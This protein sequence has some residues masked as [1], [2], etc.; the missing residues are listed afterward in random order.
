MYGA[1][2][3]EKDA[4]KADLAVLFI[5]CEGALNVLINAEL[6]CARKNS[7]PLTLLSTV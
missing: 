1:I 4:D 6:W 2:L 5:H 7:V 3:V